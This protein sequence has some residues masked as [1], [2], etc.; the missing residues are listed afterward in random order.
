MRVVLG[1]IALLAGAAAAGELRAPLVGYLSGG[2]GELRPVVGVAGS[3]IVREPILGKV[4]A[5]AFAGNFG[6]VDTGEELLLVDT[7]LEVLGRASLPATAS[8]LGVARD[9]RLGVA[10]LPDT[11][12]L[13]RL[14]PGREAGL[15]CVAV[16]P[17]GKVQALGLGAG[18]TVLLATEHGSQLWLAE[19]DLRT[20]RTLR[21]SLLPGV[22]APLWLLGADRVLY[23]QDGEIVLRLPGGAET[24]IVAPAPAEGFEAMGEGWVRLRSA[25][26]GIWALRVTGGELELF[27]LP[28]S[29][30]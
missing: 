19:V 2:S 30:R 26:G 13:C 18:R 7:D 8:H 12:E 22:T 16:A 21:E 10:Y 27:C 23:R 5:A 20:G 11:E 6:V 14:E 24:R 29:A 9:G 15:S 28:E 1:W 25:G 3:F 4:R 17:G